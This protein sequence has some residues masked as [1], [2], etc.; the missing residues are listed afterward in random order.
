MASIFTKIINGELPSY[1]LFEDDLT[2]S[3]LTI[4][5][6]QPGH[7]L[8]VPKQEVDYFIDLKSPAYERVFANAQKISRAIEK[9]TECKRIGLIVAGYEVPHFHLHMIPTWGLTDFDFEKATEAT[10]EQLQA[11]HKKIVENL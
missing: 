1:K 8:I 3:F 11:M 10:D 2:Y 6:I 4:S 5:P 9:A 7:A